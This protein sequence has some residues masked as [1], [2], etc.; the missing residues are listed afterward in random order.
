MTYKQYDYI[1][2]LFSG[3]IILK[4]GD[5]KMFMVEKELLKLDNETTQKLIK[6]GKFRR[7]YYHNEDIKAILCNN[8]ETDDD[9]YYTC[10]DNN[11]SLR[12]K[13]DMLDKE[14]SKLQTLKS[15]FK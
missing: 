13:I 12:K 14:L 15:L 5:I 7:E 10:R 8:N 9:L 3:V 11:Y 1:N 4:G 2:K 6:L